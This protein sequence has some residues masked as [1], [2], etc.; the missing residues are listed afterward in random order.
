MALLL[1]LD[2]ALSEVIPAVLTAILWPEGDKSDG[3]GSPLSAI[4]VEMMEP[5]EYG[6]TIL[7]LDFELCEICFLLI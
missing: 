2:M 7:P 1:S 5:P 4:N 3:K 6:Y